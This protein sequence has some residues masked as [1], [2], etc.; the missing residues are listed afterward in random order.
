MAIVVLLALVVAGVGEFESL[1]YFVR[2]PMR[3]G[4]T[5]FSAGTSVLAEFAQDVA[6]TSKPF[7]SQIP[8]E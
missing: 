7:G 3:G 5:E 6:K 1:P 8:S 4:I 2:N